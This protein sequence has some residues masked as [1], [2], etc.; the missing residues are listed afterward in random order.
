MRILV[1]LMFSLMVFAPQSFAQ[2][3]DYSKL[4]KKNCLLDVFY[5]APGSSTAEIWE[6]YYDK[7]RERHWERTLRLKYWSG[8]SDPMGGK[9]DE[10]WANMT[11]DEYVKYCRYMLEEERRKKAKKGQPK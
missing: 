5:E 7:Q 4:N 9:E 1:V 10:E 2:K 6:A 8:V 3:D 11:E